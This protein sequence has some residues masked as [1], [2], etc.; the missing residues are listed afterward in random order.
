VSS[1]KNYPNNFRSEIDTSGLTIGKSNP[2]EEGLGAIPVDNHCHRLLQVAD[3]ISSCGFTGFHKS[4]PVKE[5]NMCSYIPNQQIIN[6]EVTLSVS[7]W[8]EFTRNF[9][10]ASLEIKMRFAELEPP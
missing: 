6:V 1:Q 10:D 5:Y 7:I 9:V 4:K 8:R 2:A 3:C